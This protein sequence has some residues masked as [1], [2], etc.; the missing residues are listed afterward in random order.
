MKKKLQESRPRSRSRAAGQLGRK[1]PGVSIIGAGRMGTALALALKAAG[2]RIEVVV[3]KRPSHARRAVSVIGGGTLGFSV[4]QMDRLD[5]A[6]QVPF[7]RSSLI[8][9]ATPDDA[10]ADVAD[11][12]ARI[13]KSDRLKSRNGRV[14][15]HTS[16]ALS[17]EALRSLR[18]AGF[19]TGSLHP[20]VSISDSRSGPKSFAQAFFSVEG[21]PAAVRLAKSIVRDLGGQSFTIKARHKALYHAAA[22]LASPH[23]V[24]LL[25]I[26]IEMLSRCGIS[27]RD[28]RRVLLPL[29][30]STIA[31]LSTQ[32]PKRALTGTF[33][34]GDVATVRRHLAAIKS[35]GLSDALAAYQLLGKRSVSLARRRG[36][37]P[38]ELDEIERLIEDIS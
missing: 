22:L 37:K 4:I 32:D 18:D 3:T 2:Y 12:L 31:N 1:K 20:L 16:G 34:R 17:S 14:A 7:R 29:L 6:Q 13:L 25:D 5:L 38:F 10:I 15:M 24:A 21:D 35:E 19:D 23:T 28:A 27:P 36:V 8:L 30:K 11:R 26:A 9:I 33:R